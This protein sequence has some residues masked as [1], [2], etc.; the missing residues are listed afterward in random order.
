M[1]TS[2]KRFVPGVLL[3]SDELTVATVWRD[4]LSGNIEIA[5]QDHPV[6]CLVRSLSCDA[7]FFA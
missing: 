1:S 7:F 4:V 6:A 2:A 5:L 3:L